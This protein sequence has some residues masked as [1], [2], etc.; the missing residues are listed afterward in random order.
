MTLIASIGWDAVFSVKV[1]NRVRFEDCDSLGD[2][3]SDEARDAAESSGS[4]RRPLNNDGSKG[5]ET[6][7]GVFIENVRCFKS[8]IQ[9]S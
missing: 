8:K 4:L 2:E 1:F 5:G 3:A 7:G 9:I 6:K